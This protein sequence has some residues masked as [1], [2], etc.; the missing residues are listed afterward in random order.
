M[1]DYYR[2][3][4]GNK[5]SSG[6]HVDLSVFERVIFFPLGQQ[7][8]EGAEKRVEGGGEGASTNSV[9]VHRLVLKTHLEPPTGFS[10]Q[11]RAVL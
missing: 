5:Y 6:Q 7:E 2:K 8:E 3:G 4:N 10:Q 11:G 1:D 9:S